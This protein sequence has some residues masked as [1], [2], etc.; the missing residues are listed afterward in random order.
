MHGYCYEFSG[1]HY[2]YIDFCDAHR[3]V[4]GGWII[5]SGCGVLGGICN[6]WSITS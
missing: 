1:V 2:P 3:W 4:L 6:Y 5:Q